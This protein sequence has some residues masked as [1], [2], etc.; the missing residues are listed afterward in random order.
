MND[1]QKIRDLFEIVDNLAELIYN[2]L[3]ARLANTKEVMDLLDKLE[4]LRSKINDRI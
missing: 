2:Y 3:P 1:L 4:L